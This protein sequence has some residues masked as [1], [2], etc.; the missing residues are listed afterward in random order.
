MDEVVCFVGPDFFVAGFFKVALTARV[1]GQDS[2][3][4]LAQIELVERPMKQ[5]HFCVCSVP[6]AVAIFVAYQRARACRLAA[7]VDPV[8]THSANELG[9][10][11][12]R[13]DRE[14]EVGR[15]SHKTFEPLLLI[16]NHH[17]AV[18]HQVL[19]DV[20]VVYPTKDGGEVVA[21]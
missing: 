16:F 6:F 14:H 12:L 13:F 1:R 19:S 2:R 15:A 21:L 9:V 7:M 20:S 10:F 8:Q 18:R 17:G 4:H 3:S 11:T 5:V